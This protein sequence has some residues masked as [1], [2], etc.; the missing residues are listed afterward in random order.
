MADSMTVPLFPA[1]PLPAAEVESLRASVMALKQ[2]VE[3]LTGTDNHSKDGSIADRFAPHVFVQGATPK[4][5]RQGDLWLCTG[6]DYTLN[7]WDGSMWLV[8][9]TLPARPATTTATSFGGLT[10]GFSGRGP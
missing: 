7:I 10:S 1:I 5:Y 8:V 3:L 2:C 9:T 6:E 4:A